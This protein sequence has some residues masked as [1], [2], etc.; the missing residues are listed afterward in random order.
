M[1]SWRDPLDVCL[2][3][4]L[5]SAIFH[6]FIGLM[7]GRIDV[8]SVVTLTMA[9][10]MGVLTRGAAFYVA[11]AG[12]VVFSHMASQGLLVQKGWRLRSAVALLLIVPLAISSVANC[13]SPICQ[14]TLWVTNSL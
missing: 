9:F 14:T 10:S 3:V 5:F 7:N 13:R 12:F 8:W 1:R 4:L 2:S 11:Y 6:A